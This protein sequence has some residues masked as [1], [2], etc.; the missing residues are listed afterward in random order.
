MGINHMRR[1]ILFLSITIF[2]MVGAQV[3][4][5]Q[6]YNGASSYSMA[7]SDLALPAHSWSMFVN[8]AGLAEYGNTAAIFGTESPYGLSYFSHTSA[9]VQ[10]TLFGLGTFGLSIEDLATNYEGNSLSKETA[11][12]LHHG[13]TLQAD[14]N[15]T[16]RFGYSFKAYS[17]DYGMSAGPSG[18]GSDGISLGSHQ[19]FGLDAGVLASLRE[20]IR[21]GAKITNINRP[22]LGAANTAVY[23]PTRMQIGLAYSP[24][25]LVWTTAALTR[26]VR[27]DTQIHAGMNYKILPGFLIRSGVH[28]NPNRFATGFSITWKFIS[29]NYGLMTH[30]VLPFSHNLSFEILMP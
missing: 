13:L 26:S 21:F 11:L 12:A 2:S 28:S 27:H 30:P 18:D 23:L 4:T 25:D 17:V 24:Y 19:A 5:E 3:T 9:G 8:P 1:L 16:L 10:F 29:I 14:R 22:Q 15:S 20:R 7:G 6:L